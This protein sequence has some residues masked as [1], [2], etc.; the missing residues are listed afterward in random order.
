MYEQNLPTKYRPQEVSTWIKSKKKDVVPSVKPGLYGKRFVAWWNSL[1][2]SW[3]NGGNS[4]GSSPPLGET[5]EGLR[6]GGTA[7]FYL[8]I[9]GVSWWIKAQGL[10]RDD[11]AWLAVEDISWVIGE[12]MNVVTPPAATSMKRGLEEKENEARRKKT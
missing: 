8:I 4:L 10:E 2:P 6:K 12:M 1:Q 5:W 11:D 7:G 9:I 3:R